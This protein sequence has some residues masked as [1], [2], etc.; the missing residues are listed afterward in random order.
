MLASELA[1]GR[2]GDGEGVEKH[3]E[4]CETCLRMLENQRALQSAMRTGTLYHEPR[5]SLERSILRTIQKRER[6]TSGQ[7]RFGA[8]RS[9]FAA[10][11][12]R[13]QPCSY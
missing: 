6:S 9:L 8:E 10:G 4:S 12:S 7:I 11:R 3:L 2:I 13:S 5:P 1:K